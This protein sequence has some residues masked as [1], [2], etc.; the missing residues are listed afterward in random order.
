MVYK[1]KISVH[2][3]IQSILFGIKFLLCLI[4]DYFL[5]LLSFGNQIPGTNGQN[6]LKVGQQ[7]GCYGK[8]RY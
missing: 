4:N 8:L 1:K 7:V 3:C 5:L 6:F 2:F